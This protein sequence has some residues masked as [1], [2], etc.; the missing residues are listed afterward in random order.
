M[1]TLVRRGLYALGLIIGAAAIA[2]FIYREELER[3]YRVNTLFDEDVIVG[4]FSNMGSMFHSKVIPRSGP[5][6][7]FGSAPRPLPERFNGPSGDQSTEAFLKRTSTTSLLV[8]R[9]DA[10][11]FEEYYQGTSPEDLRISWSVAKSF[12]AAMLGIAVGEGAIASLDEPADK[13]APMLKGSAYEGVS[14]RN[15]AMMA[16]GVEFNEDYLDYDSDINKMGRALALNGSLDE[17]S[18]SITAKAGPPGEAWRY[19]SIDTH[20]LSMA[21]RGA[22]GKSMTDYMAE[23]IWSKI[24]AEADALYLTDTPGAEFVLGGLNMRTR[25]YARFGRVI[26]NGGVLDGVEVAPPD[27]LAEATTDI[28]PPPD[29]PARRRGHGYGYQF[30]LPDNPDGEVYFSGVYGQSMFVDQKAGVIIVKTSAD[31]NFRENNSRN[32][33]DMIALFRAIARGG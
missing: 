21:I 29:T 27:F 30:W 4:N 3:L 25:D 16:S 26:L 28:A 15:I 13:Y 9:D 6:F 7:A 12:L 10:I 2:A 31:R 17:F 32:L 11:E 1:R 23:K 19:V 5:V 8:I 24:G 33:L 20:V 14:L 22:T 18:A